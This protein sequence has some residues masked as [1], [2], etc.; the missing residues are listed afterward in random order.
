MVIIMAKVMAMMEMMM[1]ILT[2]LAVHAPLR[3]EF[4][5]GAVLQQVE[6]LL[7]VRPQDHPLD[8]VLEGGLER[9]AAGAGGHHDAPRHQPLPVGGQH[10]A[11]GQ[12]QQV[13]APPC[14][15]DRPHVQPVPGVAG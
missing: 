10:L 7:Q 3:Q 15:V 12:L 14:E 1:T 5:V 4:E 9:D 8:G 6:G 11:A 13:A 2:R